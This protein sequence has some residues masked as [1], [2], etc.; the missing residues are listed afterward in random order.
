MSIVQ[1]G[2]G[3]SVMVWVM[4]SW[5][6][7]VHLIPIEHCLNITVNLLVALLVILIATSNKIMH[8]VTKQVQTI[9]ITVSSVYFNS[10]H[11]LQN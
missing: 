9:N 2:G 4:L 11:G 7:F 10:L 5:H 6:T 8:L 1:V 3:G